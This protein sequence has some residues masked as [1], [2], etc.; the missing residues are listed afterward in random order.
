MDLLED[1]DDAFDDIFAEKKDQKPG[2]Q[3]G[4]V[5]FGEMPPDLA[6]LTAAIAGENIAPVQAILA[7]LGHFKR[8]YAL[9]AL[10]GAVTYVQGV[11]KEPQRLEQLQ[12]LLQITRTKRGGL[13]QVLV[14]GQLEQLRALADLV[15]STDKDTTQ[16]M[17]LYVTL[18]SKLD[19]INPDDVVKLFKVGLCAPER[20]LQAPMDEATTLSGLDEVKIQAVKNALLQA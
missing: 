20:M 3:G 2:E 4:I 17:R 15:G 16:N 14:K 6:E 1:L 5:S 8:A 18:L 9:A 12:Q 7:D 19:E 10:Q 13:R 11:E